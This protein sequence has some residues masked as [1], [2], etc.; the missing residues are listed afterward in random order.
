[1][2]TESD[3]KTAAARRSE[4]K[5]YRRVPRMGGSR[6][7]GEARDASV[8]DPTSAAAIMTAFLEQSVSRP[9]S[10]RRRYP[11]VSDL[12]GAAIEPKMAAEIWTFLESGIIANAANL[13]RDAQI[14]SLIRWL[15]AL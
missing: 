7:H 9:A 5:N 1:M 2:K 3:R 6:Q 4:N 11:P 15:C 13:N 10:D 12:N 8:R 14:A